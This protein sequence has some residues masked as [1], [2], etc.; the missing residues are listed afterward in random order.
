MIKA[1]IFDLDNCLAS[2]RE[3]GEELFQPAFDA[4]RR[5]N[6]GAVPEEA[7]REA[8]EECWG[9]A[10][11]WV[12][13]KHGFSDEMLRAGWEIFEKLEVKKPMTGYDDL[14]VLEDLAARRFLV[15]S[16]F[17]RLQESKIAALG[18]DR[19]FDEIVV[20]AIDEPDRQGK[21]AIFKRIMDLHQLD[22]TEVMVV[23]DNVDS[24]IE[25]GNLLGM[26]TVQTLRP[27]V[28]KTE[29]VSHHIHSLGELVAVLS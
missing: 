21:Q 20:D 3:V 8:F 13:D 10:L 23:G 29:D 18:L 12:A 24:E 5:A 19:Y 25:A 4:I 6:R 1:L 7:L 22:P 16:G 2:S 9:N 11:D 15:T 14:A 27:G 28:R 17:R 26:R